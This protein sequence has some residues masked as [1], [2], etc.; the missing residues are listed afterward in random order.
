VIVA[1]VPS[2][3]YPGGVTNA[4]LFGHL[5]SAFVFV[6]GAAGAGILQLAALRRDRPSEI[7]LLL[8]TTRVAVALLGAGALATLGFGLALVGHEG[9]GFGTGWV[10]AAIALWVA[11]MALGGLGG[12]TARH[13][14]YLAERLAAEGDRPSEELRALV[15]H[16][17]SLL[18][19]Y[20]STAAIV[21]ILVLMVWKP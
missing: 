9:I 8:Q 15:G 19:S 10:V 5:V 21:A 2:E 4:L 1:A 12:R 16:R 20:A 11:A 18:Q 7:A 14:R 3:P 13:A 17:P 6:S